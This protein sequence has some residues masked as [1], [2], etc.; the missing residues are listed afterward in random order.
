MLRFWKNW[1]QALGLTV[2]LCSTTLANEPLVPAA[3]ATGSVIP[4]A[5]ALIPPAPAIE[6]T[7]D[8]VFS[9]IPPAAPSPKPTAPKPPPQPWKPMFFDN[10]FRYKQQPNAPHFPGE[11]LKDIPA[12][13]LL[14]LDA[15][16]QLRISYG[17][18]IR[19]RYLDETNR[20]RPGGPGHTDYQQWRW[21]Q[22]VDVK[23]SDW[24]RAY[25]EMIDAS[26]FNN[27]LPLTGID[28]NRWDLQNY[29]L[30]VQVTEVLDNPVWFR[31]GRQELLYG[32]QRLISPLDWANTRRNF[33]GFKLFTKNETW[34]Y[35]AW[36][37][38]PVNT[39]SPQN[40]P[41]DRYD[42][43]PDFRN[44]NILFGGSYWTYKAVKDQTLDLFLLW[45][46]SDLIQLNYPEGDRYTLGTR[47]LGNRP[48]AEGDR[49]W[50]AEIEGGYQFGND[51]STMTE[52]AAPRASVEAGYFTGG[53]GHT[54]KAAPWEPNLWLFYDWAS[55][56]QNPNDS[57]NNTFFQ[58]YGLV[59]AYLGLI[60]NVA[61]QN[62]QD[63]N[64]RLTVKPHQK[65]TMQVA[66]HWFLLANQNDVLYNVAGARVGTPNNG[67]EI[68]QELDFVCTFNM[69]TNWSFEAG[70]FWFWYGEYIGNT[71]PRGTAQQIYLMNTLR[72]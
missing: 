31:V 72:Y 16:E 35:D 17:G 56:D 43:S 52:I 64:Y 13:S 25:V 67:A 14:D 51:R 71:A 6:I 59:H 40:G 12:G 38:N 46:H 44:R 24:L 9:Q 47:W 4:A 45:S 37:V 66:Q 21:R 7:T 26:T 62:I 5:A 27:D 33:E 20:L 22:Y 53:V 50:H 58:H 11:E 8:G 28:V 1:R 61:R 68:G 57:M 49:I 42:H 36:L 41:L 54:W 69:T 19:F 18:E 15:V 70:Y 32:N 2:C 39:A 29:L 34:D 63:L 60:D 30:D 65:M 55:G 23:Q 48:V 10:D 3:D